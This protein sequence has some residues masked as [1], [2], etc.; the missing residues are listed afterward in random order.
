MTGKKFPIENNAACQYKWAWSSLYLN[1]GTTASCHRCRHYKFDTETITNFHNLPG[2]L[3]DRASMLKG[4]WPG[5][6]CEYCRDIEAVGG[7]SDR[8]AFTNKDDRILPPELEADHTA[9]AVTPT[10]L[11]VYF[12]NTC[13]QSCVYCRPGFSSQIE[14]EVKKF[15]P[16]KYNQDYSS[17]AGDDRKNYLT[18]RTKFFEWMK[19]NGNKLV[20]FKM[21]GGEPLYQEEFD[22]LLDHF[23]NYPCPNLTWD[24]FTNLN[25]DTDKFKAK[26]DKISKL[27]NEKKLKGLKFICSIDCWGPDVEYVRY[28]FNMNNAEQ[29][30]NLLLETNGVDADVHATMS[31]LSLPSMYLLAEKVNEWGRKKHVALGWNT[32]TYPPCFDIYHFGNYFLKDLDKFISTLEKSDTYGFKAQ[33]KTIYGIRSRMAEAKPNVEQVEKLY[34]FL[35]ELDVRRKEDWKSRF[36]EVA[37][38]MKE[39]I[40][41]YK[42]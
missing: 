30:M 19:V 26:V 6:G 10:I 25:H 39:V 24:I 2:K 17:F 28:G 31:V 4:E 12:S 33:Q 8:I 32:I 35:E 14:H 11:E 27:I 34:G 15:G 42:K 38:A 7:I 13:N 20:F 36:P 9:V 3:E 22:M 16:S 41:K 29:N 37:N 21:L 18:Y 23:E 1:R 5:N 40:E